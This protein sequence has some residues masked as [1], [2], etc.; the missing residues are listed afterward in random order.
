MVN[1]DIAAICPVATHTAH[2]EVGQH[3]HR[4]FFA[5][6]GVFIDQGL[7]DVKGHCAVTTATANRLRHNA[8]GFIAVG[9]DE[10]CIGYCHIAGDISVAAHA[11][12]GN[13]HH[14]VFVLLFNGVDQNRH[15]AITATTTN[16]QCGY[17][18]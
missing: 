14:G 2:G 11:P 4:R 3:S 8:V 7:I 9:G 16:T 13:V 10:T 5:N 18:V 1:R 6:V 17:T 15:I 12:N